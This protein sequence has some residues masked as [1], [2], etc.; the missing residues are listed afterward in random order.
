MISE[1]FS[2]SECECLLSTSSMAISAAA[3]AAGLLSSRSPLWEIVSFLCK[4][5]SLKPTVLRLFYSSP[6][7]MILRLK[8]DP[9]RLCFIVSSPL[10]FP[11]FLVCYGSTSRSGIFLN[12]SL[13]L[14]TERPRHAA[15]LADCGA[16]KLPPL[17]LFSRAGVSNND[18][19]FKTFSSRSFTW[20]SPVSSINWHFCL[21]IYSSL[22][23]FY[24]SN[25]FWRSSIS[26]NCVSNFNSR[27]W[28]I[29]ARCL[30]SFWSSSF[31]ISSDTT[32]FWLPAPLS[33]VFCNS[34]WSFSSCTSNLS[35][36]RLYSAR[37]VSDFSSLVSKAVLAFSDYASLTSR[38]FLQSSNSRS[39]SFITTKNRD[40]HNVRFWRKF[41]IDTTFET[42]WF[43]NAS[44]NVFI[45]V[46]NHYKSK[47]TR[48][49]NK[50]GC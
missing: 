18:L 3:D 39:Y 4:L 40:T 22:C 36:S 14:V 46:M 37:P 31:S 33:K 23:N 13:V 16:T 21:S 48:T 30:V 26:S 44:T 42:N 27:S 5:S 28:Y 7:T 8:W 9:S 50:Y 20:R 49:K 2:K 15:V 19:N 24:S 32:R 1:A 29:N 35:A 10:N 41:V 12:S 6:S 43:D 38:S 45:N 25:S 34:F 17:G 11:P 47:H